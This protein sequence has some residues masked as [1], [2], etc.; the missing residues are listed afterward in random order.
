ME[1]SE[2][3]RLSWQSQLSSGIKI[4]YASPRIS[5]N[6]RSVGNR[7][8]SHPWRTRNSS[9]P[10]LNLLCMHMAGAHEIELD[11]SIFRRR[12][13]N[14][15][16]VNC[17]DV[18]CLFNNWK[19]IEMAQRFS[20][21]TALNVHEKGFYNSKTISDWKKRT[22]RVSKLLMWRQLGSLASG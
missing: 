8:H 18:R 11:Q 15:T 1:K 21:K 4:P 3:T 14:W 10:R 19:G 13:T 6:T 2:K 17:S 5:R 7:A 16:T 20:L 12:K 22:I 9:V